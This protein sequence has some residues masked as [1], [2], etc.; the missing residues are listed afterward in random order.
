MRPRKLAAEVE[1]GSLRHEINAQTYGA[2]FSHYDFADR[3]RCRDW[4]LPAYALPADLQQ[5]VIQQ[6]VI[7]QILA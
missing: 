2:G 6:M 3:L 7:Q 5:M 1:I 4:H